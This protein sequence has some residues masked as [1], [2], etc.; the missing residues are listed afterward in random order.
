MASFGESGMWYIAYL[1]MVAFLLVHIIV[2]ISMDSNTMPL[3]D[4]V[5]SC[6]TFQVLVL[7]W[8]TSVTSLTWFVAVPIRIGVFGILPLAK[9][10]E[11]GLFW[12]MSAIVIGIFA[13]ISR[14]SLI[15]IARF[16]A[17]DSKTLDFNIVMWRSTQL[18]G[19]SFVYSIMAIIGGCWSA[20]KAA[21][22][23]YDLSMWSSF[24]QTDNKVYNDISSKAIRA[25]PLTADGRSA[26]GQYIS[27]VGN[28]IGSKLSSPTFMTSWYLILI[29]TLQ[30][31]VLI[32]SSMFKNAGEGENTQL[33]LIILT[34]EVNIFFILDAVLLLVPGIRNRLCGYPARMEYVYGSLGFVILVC[35]YFFSDLTLKKFIDALNLYVT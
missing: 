10:P 20:Y 16:T 12:G 17:P 33:L 15:Q 5:G 18:W 25:N 2:E 27:M 34:T 4:F 1:L 22:W 30:V 23:D 6:V 26:Y 32:Y 11:E 35:V 3:R 13:G 21:F 19:I 7:N 14:D 24:K 29:F 9:S 8:L 31:A 28:I